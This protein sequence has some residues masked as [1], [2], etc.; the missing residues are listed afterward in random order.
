MDSILE[1]L[2]RNTDNG[3]RNYSIDYRN[4]DSGWRIHCIRTR[5]TFNAGWL[6]KDIGLF[7]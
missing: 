3:I 5:V 1:G 2:L 4:A 6:M 7:H